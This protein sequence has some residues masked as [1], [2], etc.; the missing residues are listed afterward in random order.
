MMSQ[1]CAMMCVV[2]VCCVEVEFCWGRG[3]LDRQPET[4]EIR[5]PLRRAR[6]KFL[7]QR[8]PHFRSQ[9]SLK[10][11]VWN[12][13]RCPYFTGCPLFPR[14]LFTG[15]NCTVCC[16]CM[17]QFVV[18]LPMTRDHS[19]LKDISCLNVQTM[20]AKDILCL[21][22]CVIKRMC[23]SIFILGRLAFSLSGHVQ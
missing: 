9:F 5:T 18:S 10:T 21:I 11:S 15:F 16:T 4:C 2:F 22:L 14:M 3:G 1:L 19:S 8:C 17:N 13:A 20:L 12:Q 7:I 23:I 6:Q